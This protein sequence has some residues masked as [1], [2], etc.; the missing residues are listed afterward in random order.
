MSDAAE[1]GDA[2][3]DDLAARLDRLFETLFSD[4]ER[5]A[6]RRVV[7]EASGSNETVAEALEVADEAED[8]ARRVD[9][10]ELADAVD[11]AK[12]PDAIDADAVA[13]GDAKRTVKL[14]KLLAAVEFT[15]VV[16]SADIREVWRE[17]R[18]L[19]EAIDRF[20]GD[21]EEEGDGP[22]SDDGGLLDGVSGGI[23]A[24]DEAGGLPGGIGGDD[25]GEAGDE[26]DGLGLSSG[27]G[28]L[29]GL[30]EENA[31]MIQRATQSEMLKAVDEFRKGLLEVHEDLAAVREETRQATRSRQRRTA[32]SR[33]PTAV[34]TMPGGEPLGGG[35][36]KGSTVPRET[37][38]STAPNRKRIYGHRFEEELDDE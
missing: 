6:I 13:D 3:G 25:G 37:R 30:D 27:L 26:D 28:D 34:S 4:E 32:T 12:L 5:D 15:K 11:W 33:N 1:A 9:L 14:R 36:M 23:S 7:E 20:L 29:G 16:G 35:L 21:G 22:G 19:D 31:E 17:S 8:V 10:G 18:E 2:E 24:G 38:Y